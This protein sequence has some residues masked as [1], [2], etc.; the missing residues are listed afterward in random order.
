MTAV[1]GITEVDHKTEA[2]ESV[3]PT[4]HAEPIG[5]IQDFDYFPPA[6]KARSRNT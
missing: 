3:Q 6:S 5:L 4:G 2:P 1:P